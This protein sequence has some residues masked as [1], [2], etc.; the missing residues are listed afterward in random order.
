[1]GRPR[2]AVDAPM[3]AAPI[4]VDRAVEADI[5]GFVP[6]DDAP[7][8]DLLHL[9]GKCL[10]LGKRFPAVVDGLIAAR[11]VGLRPPAM[12]ATGRNARRL[13]RGALQFVGFSQGNGHGLYMSSI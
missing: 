12:P 3:L 11:A 2:E 1:M 4:R 9:G 8:R 6:G 13:E 5:G 10:E 7:R